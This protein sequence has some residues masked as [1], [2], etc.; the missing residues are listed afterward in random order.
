MCNVLQVKYSYIMHQISNIPNWMFLSMF[1]F[2]E[3]WDCAI[4]NASHKW[5]YE[6]E[7][8]N[9]S[10]SNSF[11]FYKKKKFFYSLE[12]VWDF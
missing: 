5:K 11:P 4:C 9:L 10:S 12:N 8:F 2:H 6:N 1:F 7:N 3:I